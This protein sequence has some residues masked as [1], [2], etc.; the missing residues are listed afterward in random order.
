ML[1]T[2]NKKQISLLLQKMKENPS[3]AG[4]FSRDSKEAVT[5]FWN[6]AVVDLNSA[7]PPTKSIAEWKK[8]DISKYHIIVYVMYMFLFKI[9]V[10]IDQKRY[11]IK[12]LLNITD[13]VLEQVVGHQ[14]V[15]DSLPLKKLFTN[16]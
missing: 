2:T 8:V 4:G 1:R 12:K 3:I 9:K 15:V 14:S 5:A 11:T 7:G 16:L 10:W 6:D 13:N